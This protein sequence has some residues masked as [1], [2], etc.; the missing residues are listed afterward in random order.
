LSG[1]GLPSISILISP[2]ERKKS[3][4]NSICKC[5]SDLLLPLC[6]D[7]GGN[8]FRASSTVYDELMLSDKPSVLK[9]DNRLLSP[10]DGFQLP[11]NK[12]VVGVIR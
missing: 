6:S 8:Y 7:M 10:E 5:Y 4:K 12:I 3:L 9:F 1:A 11:K 2:H